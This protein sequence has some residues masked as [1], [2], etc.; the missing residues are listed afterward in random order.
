M[1]KA[2][3]T[4]VTGKAVTT[5]KKKSYEADSIVWNRGLDGPRADPSM[6]L[7]DAGPGAQVHMAKEVVG[8][9]V[10]EVQ[11]GNGSTVTVIIAD[12]HTVTVIDNGRG[13]PVA[14]HALDKKRSTLD[15]VFSELHA[16]GKGKGSGDAY[17]TSIGTHG[18]GA[19][20]T[21][22]CSEIFNVEV[23][24][25]GKVH[26]MRWAKGKVKKAFKVTG[27]CSK[28]ETGTTVTFRH[29]PTVLSGKPNWKK[30]VDWV[31]ALAYFT[32]KVTY[33]LDI[34]P[35]KLKTKIHRKNGLA[36]WLSDNAP[37]EDSGF[38]VITKPI[39]VQTK[40]MDLALQ[41]YGKPE[42]GLRSYVSA[43]ETTEGGT[44][45]RAVEK[46]ISDVLDK[47]CGKRGALKKAYKPEDLRAGLIGCVNIRMKAPK[48]HNQTKEKLTSPEGEE[49]VYAEAVKGLT[50]YFSK[51]KSV[52]KAIIERANRLRGAHND[53]KLSAA[54]ASK[55]T[56]KRGQFSLP[57]KLAISNAK[58]RSKV[59][60]YIVEGD[61]AGGSAKQA[62][63]ATFQ[64][65]LPLKGKPPNILKGNIAKHLEN[66]EITNVL[67]AIGYDPR[68]K[69]NPLAKMRVGKIIL[70]ADSDVD[71]QHITNLL[72]SVFWV[73]MPSLIRDG[74][75]FIVSD[76]LYMAKNATKTMFG[77]TREEAIE[78]LGS[79]A[80]QV[81][82]IKGWGELNADDMEPFVFT[83]ETRQHIVLTP[84]NPQK[85]M[86]VM[87]EDVSVRKR[88][89]NV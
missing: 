22:A 88:L 89:L 4:T 54:A 61:S 1:A 28:A 12:D 72:L 85:L 11:A 30:L 52:A 38:E 51:H 58:D 17:D 14:P 50:A 53:F 34:K 27:K 67:K 8:N 44:H 79:K 41:W 29:D 16:G 3:K 84:E 40:A 7:G 2:V 31:E 43:V 59:E 19:A 78:R 9:A 25:E 10:D 64:E 32:P 86:E 21:N 13:V 18:L 68:N 76:A 74:K 69:E 48:F 45:H 33:V 5:K 15:I 23:K 65:V 46:A 24:R 60:L 70:L 57:S 26:E 73:L 35:L 81:T 49:I 82:R 87:G 36:D 20:V 39:I 71:G 56:G 75:V 66:D 62:R 63:D 6:Y 77:K 55:I 83:P 80:K 42:D 37:K 47:F